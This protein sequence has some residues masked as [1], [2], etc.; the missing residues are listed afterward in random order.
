[1]NIALFDRHGFEQVKRLALWHAV[2]YVDE[3]NICQFLCRDP[4]CGG[5]ADIASAYDTDF[6]PHAI[7][8]GHEAPKRVQ[9]YMLPMM[10]VANS[11]VPTLV[12]PAVWRSKSY[13]TNFCRMVFSIDVSMS[14]AASFQPMK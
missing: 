8:P 4:M 11:L 12:A 7:S 13:V 2:H 1:M 9:C 10:R 6:F 5:G 14:F 3:H